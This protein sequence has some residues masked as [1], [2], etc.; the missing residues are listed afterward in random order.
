MR[1]EGRDIDIGRMMDRWTLQMGYPVV[2]I[3][4]NQSEQLLTHY[5]SVSQEHF[6]YGQEVGNN[7]RYSSPSAGDVS[8]LPLLRDR[9]GAAALCV[10][11][12]SLRTPVFTSVNSISSFMLFHLFLSPSIF[13]SRSPRPIRCALSST[14]FLPHQYFIS[15]SPLFSTCCC[16]LLWLGV[17]TSDLL[18]HLLSSGQCCLVEVKSGFLSRLI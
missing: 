14:H 8:V 1:S 13:Y 17:L 6:L 12:S 7:Y 3:S 5:I 9:G 2:T 16:P 4:K 18:S 11:F 15:S 10:I